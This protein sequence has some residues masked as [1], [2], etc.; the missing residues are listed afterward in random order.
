MVISVAALAAA[1]LYMESTTACPAG[2]G[3]GSSCAD[4][5]SKDCSPCTPPSVALKAFV[6][7]NAATTGLVLN[8]F[9]YMP[10]VEVLVPYLVAVGLTD[11]PKLEGVPAEVLDD[12]KKMIGDD[13]ATNDDGGNAITYKQNVE[14]EVHD[15]EGL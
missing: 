12:T 4:F 11:M 7:F 1:V 15:E 13:D 9:G 6:A 5:S 10:I 8:W 3:S 14:G 2:S